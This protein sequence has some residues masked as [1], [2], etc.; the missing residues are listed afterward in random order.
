MDGKFA[1]STVNIMA[2]GKLQMTE[3][4]Q[5]QLVLTDLHVAPYGVLNGANLIIKATSVTVEEGGVINLNE[6]GDFK[7]GDGYLPNYGAGH[8]G[9]GGGYYNATSKAY[10]RGSAYDDYKEPTIAGSGGDTTYGGGVLKIEATGTVEI[11][12]EIGAE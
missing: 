2:E 8:S 5:Y 9:E 4:I 7:S 12:G 3:D 11:D 10:V 1:I 6:G